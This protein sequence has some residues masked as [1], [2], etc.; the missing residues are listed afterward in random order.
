MKNLAIVASNVYWTKKIV[1]ARR[2][3]TSRFAQ[4]TKVIKMATG[5]NVPELGGYDYEFTSKVPEDWECLV[6][7][8]LYRLWDVD[9]DSVTS[10][11]NPC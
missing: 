6:C 11:W 2:N 9:I 1:H 5:G 4:K 7:Q 8:I 3:F 10:V